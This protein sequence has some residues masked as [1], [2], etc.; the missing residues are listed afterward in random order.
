MLTP[1]KIHIIIR[2]FCLK[3]RSFIANSGTK[4]AILLNG[5]SSTAN[6]GT[7]AAVLLGIDAVASRCLYRVE[8]KQMCHTMTL[9]LI[10]GM[11]LRQLCMYGTSGEKRVVRRD[12]Q[13]LD[14][15]I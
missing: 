3:G 1:P 12:E 7:Q 2:V 11:L 8:G 10:Q 9:R 15:V 6:S 4:A 14:H 5:T 13:V